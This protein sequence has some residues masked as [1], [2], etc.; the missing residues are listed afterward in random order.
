MPDKCGSGGCKYCQ[1]FVGPVHLT[2]MVLMFLFATGFAVLVVAWADFC[3]KADDNFRIRFSYYTKDSAVVNMSDYYIY[4]DKCDLNAGLDACNPE[5]PANVN[6]YNANISTMQ[7]TL[8]SAENE[9]EYLSDELATIADLP[10]YR[11]N[12]QVQDDVKLASS[13]IDQFALSDFST[14]IAGGGTWPNA[15]YGAITGELSALHCF[16]AN[17][18]YQATVN[19]ACSSAFD[20]FVISFEAVLSIAVW[21]FFV[22]VCVRDWDGVNFCARRVSPSRNGFKVC[23]VSLTSWDLKRVIRSNIKF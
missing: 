16:Q 13:Y 10:R 1:H 5:N 23:F 8:A 14:D 17:F 12:Q 21:M 6:L 11:R 3:Y 2:F 15:S 9:T 19:Q 7:A 4:C 22:E 20:P 18:R